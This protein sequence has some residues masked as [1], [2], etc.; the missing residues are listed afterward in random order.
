[1][2]VVQFKKFTKFHALKKALDLQVDL[3]IG[4]RGRTYLSRQDNTFI[5]KQY[6]GKPALKFLPGFVKSYE[7]A[8]GQMAEEEEEVNDRIE[9]VPFLHVGM[10]FIIKPW[11]TEMYPVNSIDHEGVVRDEYNEL[12]HLI[13][14]R[15]VNPDLKEI[16]LR[17]A[18][19]GTSFFDYKY[20]KLLFTDLDFE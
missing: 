13:E 16:L 15:T 8:V 9:I 20:N 7:N 6:K 11:I 4:H 14:T 5:V 19:K 3:D 18:N 12:I 10:D 1:M 2:P 17:S